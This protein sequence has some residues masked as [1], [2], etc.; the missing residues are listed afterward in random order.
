MGLRYPG[1]YV[2][3]TFN[4]LVYTVAAAN[5]LVVAGGGG[6]GTGNA[7]GSSGGGGGVIE[8][9]TPIIPP[10]L[11]IVQTP[12]VNIKLSGLQNGF[13]TYDNKTYFDTNTIELNPLLL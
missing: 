4:P 10:T 6:G 5:L 8:A 11:P 9:P 1:N 2:T 3:A 12:K 13:V 7:G